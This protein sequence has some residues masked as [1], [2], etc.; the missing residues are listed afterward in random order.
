[1]ALG[2]SQQELKAHVEGLSA[3]LLN[4]LLHLFLFLLLWQ[5]ADRSILSA[6]IMLAGLQRG[7]NKQTRHLSSIPYPAFLLI[8]DKNS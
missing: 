4:D 3:S 6:G 7:R 8:A 5:Y 1:M 2:E